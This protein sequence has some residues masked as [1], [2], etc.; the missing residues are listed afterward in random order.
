MSNKAGGSNRDWGYASYDVDRYDDYSDSN[1]QYTSYEKSGSVNR[2]AD[3]GDGG[4]SYA[5]YNSSDNYNTGA[6]SDYSRNS[7]NSSSNPSIG[8]VQSSGGCYLTTAC[9]KHM[10]EEFYDNC[11]EL[12]ILRWFRDKYVSKDDIDHYYKIA[13]IIVETIDKL[14]DNEK[15][16]KYIYENIV[17]TC[18]KAIK[19]GNYE[20]AYNRY[21]NSILVLEEQYARKTLEQKLA[22]V[23]KLRPISS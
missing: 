18:V 5:H 3:N 14:E 13:P 21:K 15:I 19:N 20:F 4:H 6:V 23:L 16:Y 1:L 8:E 9:M 17:D 7:S 12:T 10:Q 2:Y 22:N 11:E